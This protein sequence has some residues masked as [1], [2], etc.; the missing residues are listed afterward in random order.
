MTW[1]EEIEYYG[2]AM[3]GDKLISPFMIGYRGEVQ[4][5][6]KGGGESS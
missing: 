1:V 5:P 6:K 3:Q 4:V 2:F